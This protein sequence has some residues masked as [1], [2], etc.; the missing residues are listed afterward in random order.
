MYRSWIGYLL[1]I[2]RM[3]QFVIDRFCTYTLLV[4]IYRR[5]TRIWFPTLWRK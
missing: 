4:F 5:F 1:K 2:K 3:I